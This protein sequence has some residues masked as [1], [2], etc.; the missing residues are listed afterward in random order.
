[1]AN[2]RA[3]AKGPGTCSEAPGC[4]AEYIRPTEQLVPAARA[5]PGTA[6]CATARAAAASATL[7]NVVH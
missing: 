1:M 3:Q 2:R 6:A 4:P 7:I 5:T